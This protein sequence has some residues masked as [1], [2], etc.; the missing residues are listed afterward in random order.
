MESAF[1]VTGKELLAER[2]QVEAQGRTATVESRTNFCPLSFDFHT[3]ELF[4]QSYR[5][6]A[7]CREATSGSTRKNSNSREQN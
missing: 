5:K 2:L 7:T 1:K 4:F 3:Q 6:R